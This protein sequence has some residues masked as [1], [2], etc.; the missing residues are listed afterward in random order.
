VARWLF[1][2]RK[3]SSSLTD[4]FNLR[5]AI[6]AVRRFCVWLLRVAF[7]PRPLTAATA[8]IVSCRVNFSRLA[9]ALTVRFGW[10]GGW[11]LG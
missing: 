4:V 2:S 5:P 3:P 1:R 7:P 6:E 10:S 9:I 11:V 8:E